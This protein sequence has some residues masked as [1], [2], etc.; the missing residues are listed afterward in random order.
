MNTDRPAQLGERSVG[1]AVPG[2]VPIATASQGPRLMHDTKMTRNRSLRGTGDGNDLAH[3]ALAVTD[4]MKDLEAQGFGQEREIA[5]RRL[6]HAVEI[7]RDCQ[8]RSLH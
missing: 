6:E 3:G 4:G 2:E 1:H 7:R 5:R 8:R